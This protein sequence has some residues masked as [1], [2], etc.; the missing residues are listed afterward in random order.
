MFA[1][2]ILLCT[3]FIFGTS[4][5]VISY[6]R[7]NFKLFDV[8]Y[9]KF[10][11]NVIESIKKT[12]QFFG[13][14]D[15]ANIIQT[16][17]LVENFTPYIKQLTDLMLT[18][19]NMMRE[20]E[21]NLK[22][23]FGEAHLIESDGIDFCKDVGLISDRIA[24]HRSKIQQ[25]NTI[26]ENEG[27][28]GIIVNLYSY[29]L[30]LTNCFRNGPFKNKPLI[31]SPLLIE[32]ALIVSVFHPIRLTV[33]PY[34]T[35]NNPCQI[36][37]VIIDYRSRTVDARLDQL[38]IELSNTIPAHHIILPYEQLANI[39][40][41]PYNANGYTNSIFLNCERGCMPIDSDSKAE[42]IKDNFSSSQYFASNYEQSECLKDYASLIRQRV[43]QM[44]PIQILN[45][46]ENMCEPYAERTSATLTGTSTK[47]CNSF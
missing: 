45:N 47:F 35:F 33:M 42:C 43:E 44:F 14:S 5:A 32:L 12:K 36:Q 20:I 21:P 18:F 22:D 24:S 17:D 11:A 37:D 27:Q 25:Y 28:R 19:E 30:E 9:S 10:E 40:L 26:G 46:I 2:Q 15:V 41:K 39:R 6:D 8:H 34:G 13:D 38:N 3:V 7:V 31:G 29:L 16:G 23:I 4:F 1:F